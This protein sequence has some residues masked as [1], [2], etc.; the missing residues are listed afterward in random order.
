MS[1]Y[2]DY[3]TLN[4]VIENALSAELFESDKRPLLFQRMRDLRAKAPK[5][6]AE[7]TQLRLDLMFLNNSANH[8]GIPPILIWL[9]NAR[10]LV[11]GRS[12]QP[13]FEKLVRRLEESPSVP[14]VPPTV[15][16][17]IHNEA[18]LF[19]DDMLPYGYLEAG[20]AAGRAVARLRTPRYESGT[21]TGKKYWGTGWLLTESLL[22]TNH[23]VFNARDDYQPAAS[24]D[25][26]RQQAMKTAV[27]FD[28]DSAN[29]DTDPTPVKEL[30]HWD[31]DLDYAVVRVPPQARRPLPLE[32]QAFFVK[33]NEV[34]PLNIIQHPNGQSKRIAIRNNLATTAASIDQIRYFTSTLGGSSG[35]PILNDEWKVVGIHRGSIGVKV[36]NFQG[37]TTA[38]INVGSKITSVL[39][40]LPPELRAEIV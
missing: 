2:L 28:V 24:T 4:E 39:D 31:A 13:F 15:V 1:E 5:G 33:P 6:N 7:E 14:A 10:P 18:I 25:D 19:E 30:L 35:S 38:M 26:F 3:Q 9:E 11:A 16:T 20:Y 34:A 12:E 22:I 23:H 27:Q 37:K 8:D 29:A 21:A 36:L 32:P 17:E 40:R